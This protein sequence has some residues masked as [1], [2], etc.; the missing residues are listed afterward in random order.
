MSLRGKCPK[1]SQENDCKLISCLSCGARLP[2][3]DTLE[4]DRRLA[5]AAQKAAQ[6]PIQLPETQSEQQSAKEALQSGRYGGNNSQ[7][8]SNRLQENGWICANCGS[9][10]YPKDVHDGNNCL[11]CILLFFFLLP[12][13]IY[14]I[15]DHTTKRKTCDSCGSSDMI[16]I[17]TPRGRELINRYHPNRNS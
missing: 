12:G 1:C 10:G 2:W 6:T 14:F 15:W 8:S 17:A 4:K 13:L 7:W 16:K 3:A 11:G 9:M 5:I